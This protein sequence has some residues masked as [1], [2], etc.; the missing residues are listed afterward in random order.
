VRTLAHPRGY[1]VRTSGD[2]RWIVLG[3][4]PEKSV[5]LHASDLSPGSSLPEDF[6][7]AGKNAA[8]SRDGALLAIA[9][10]AI[11]GL[12]RTSDGAVIAHLETSRSGTYAPELAFSPD[13]AQLTICW[14][15]GLLTQWDLRELRRELAARGLD[16]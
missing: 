8:L 15:N 4:G 10:G 5:L 11:I 13:G 6:Q 9:A 16:W 12:V 1:H 2:G 7:G 3:T 14:E